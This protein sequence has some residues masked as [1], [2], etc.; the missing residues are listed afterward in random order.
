M[1]EFASKSVTINTNYLTFIKICLVCFRWIG[2]RLEFLGS[3]LV[4]AAA[5]FSIVQTGINGAD[6]GLSLTYSMQVC[7]AIRYPLYIIRVLQYTLNSS[8]SNVEVY[9]SHCSQSF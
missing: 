4:L 9:H 5:V 7:V 8:Y 2:V 3:L 1:C 6:I